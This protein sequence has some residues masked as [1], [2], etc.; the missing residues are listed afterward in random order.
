M[1]RNASACLCLVLMLILATSATAGQIT[2]QYDFEQP[3]L[4]Q[5]KIEGTTYHRLDMYNAPNCGKIGEPALPAQGAQILLPYGAEIT[6]IAILPGEKVYLGDYL[7]AP[8]PPQVKLSETPTEPVVA[9]PNEE[10][11][12][13]DQPFPGHFFE[14]IGVQVFRGYAIS[15]LRLQP[16]QWTPATGE[17]YY[18]PRLTVIINTADTR[19]EYGTFRGLAED[20][21]EALTKVDNPEAVS[22][23]AAAGK[24]GDRL[25]DL[26]IITTSAMESSFQT[27]KDFH[28]SHGV[29]TD[30]VTIDDIGSN[31]P[32]DIRAYIGGRYMMEGFS[33]VLIA[34]DDALIPAKD[35]YVSLY[36]S[37]GETEY[38]MP[39]D[40]YFGCLDGTWNYDNDSYWG[41]P[42]DGDGGGPLDLE[43]DVWV[44]RAAS[45]TAIEADR[46]VS[47]TI[48]Y[49]TGAGAYLQQMLFVGEYLGFGG[50]AEYAHMY[51][52]EM[53]DGSSMHGYTT[54][55]IPSDVFDI[56]SLYEFNYNWPQADL[57]AEINSGLHILNHLGHG[58][59]DYAMKL[60]NSDLL[61]D[62]T[63]TDHCFVYSQTCSAGHMDGT[64]CWAETAN[65]KIDAGAF[66]VIMNARYGFGEFNSTD[67]A[68]QRYNREF[69]DAVFSPAEGKLELGRANADSKEDNIYRITDDYMR[70]V[71]YELNLFGDPTVAFRGVTAIA[72]QYPSGLP[73]MV[74]P[75]EPTVI[76]VNV[77][78]IGDGVPV[79]GSGQLH[80]LI[81]DGPLTTVDM[82]E[83]FPNQ[84]QVTLPGIACGEVFKFYVSAEEES[85]GRMYDPNPASPHVVNAVTDVATLFEDGF[86]TD[87]GWTISGGNWGRG[88]PLGAGGSYGDPDPASAYSGMNVFGYN[89]GGDYENGMSERHITSPA[90][91]CSGKSDVQ[92]SFMRW[93]GV[94]TSDYDH[95]YV[96]ISNNG[97]TWTTIWENGGEVN[98]GAWTSQTYD[99][100]AVADNQP[101][102][103]LRFTMGT[104]DGGWTYCGWNIDDLAVTANI[105]DDTYM[106]GDADKNAIVNV[107]DAVCILQYIFGD[108]SAVSPMPGGDC[109]CNGF[110]NIVD[111]VYIISHI[112]GGGPAPCAM[113]E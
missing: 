13:S 6:S 1:T 2:M 79:P 20:A 51:L 39:G 80:Y 101:T 88:I 27:L 43:F 53:V 41:E 44:G 70:W 72:F 23:Y 55:G 65:V 34:A 49:L 48:Q 17:L 18:Y 85:F 33:Y 71:Y 86:E 31:D 29:T 46:F 3:R 109:D 93:L 94:E 35:L 26:L 108:G 52:N 67:G 87:L 11:Y 50:D 81:N 104:T 15:V 113:C 75:N 107:A 19:K 16:V 62:L 42:N 54:V 56:D 61:S 82:N 4:E 111:A 32:D 103:Y 83:I 8:V 98:D 102:V 63:N 14:D 84:Y 96:R 30:L 7:L 91:D 78:G 24:R 58:A 92:L 38:A 112:F 100:S 25:F 74:A 28:D 21:S 36:E 76:Q 37:G 57:V 12:K 110:C 99:I 45:S 106:C 89:L 105:C 90:I 95:A 5:V 10:I 40:L 73:E 59:P 68:S 60:Y 9:K 22:S 66:A 64:T 77:S 47:K 69:W 97:T